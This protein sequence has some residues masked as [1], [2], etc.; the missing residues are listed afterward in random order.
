MYLK[1]W[2]NIFNYKG[3]SKFSELL[4]NMFINI[5]ILFLIMLSGS[6]VPLKWE[7][8]VVDIYYLILLIMLLPTLSM[9]VRVVRKYINKFKN[10]N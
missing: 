7:N 8:T 10:V 3:V 4:I 1:Y 5:T 9:A 6:I 2:K